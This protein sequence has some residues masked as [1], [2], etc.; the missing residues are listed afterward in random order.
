[1]DDELFKAAF[2]AC[3]FQNADFDAVARNETINH[4]RF[5][6]PDSMAPIS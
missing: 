2:S 3:F 6:L 1:V 4:H 5:R